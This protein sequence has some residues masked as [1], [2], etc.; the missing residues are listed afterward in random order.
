MENLRKQV[1]DLFNISY[2]CLTLKNTQVIMKKIVSFAFTALIAASL[3]SCGG[4]DTPVNDTPEVTTPA[5][6][7]AKEP[8]ITPAKVEEATGDASFTFDNVEW[9]FGTIDQGDVVEHSFEFTNTGTEPLIISNAKGSC[10][11]TVPVWP[12][13]PIAVGATGT[14]SVKFNSKGKKNKQHKRVTLTANTTPNQTVLRVKGEVTAPETTTA[15][16]VKS[17]GT[18]TNKVTTKGAT[19][20]VGSSKKRA[21]ANKSAASAASK[22]K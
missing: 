10:G 17:G 19:S 6:N 1:E 13:E 18:T 8:K 20:K 5:K 9:D 16:P 21:D 12:R 22:R 7:N 14:I 15:T 3:V 2:F 11:C 4:S